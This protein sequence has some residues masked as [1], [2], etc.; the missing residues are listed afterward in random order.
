MKQAK[1][2]IWALVA[3]LFLMGSCRE[4]IIKTGTNTTPT[5]EPEI[6]VETSVQGRVFDAN[7]NPIP[8]AI[9]TVRDIQTKTDKNGFYFISGKK[10][11]QNGS[12]M[13][14]ERAGYFDGFKMI[15]ARLGKNSFV[16]FQMINLNGSYSGKFVNNQGAVVSN[17]SGVK[18]TFE[19]NE[20]TYDDGTAFDGEVL[21]FSHFIDPSTD[22]LRLEMPGDLRGFTK[23]GN[24][25]QL[26]TAGMVAVQLISA[27]GKKLQVKKGSTVTMEINIVED[28]QATAPSEI[29]LWSFD[30]SNGFWVEEGL[31]KR[32]GN[33]YIG[34]VAHFSYWN[35]DSSLPSVQLS[36]SATA[37]G[38]AFVHGHVTIRLNGLVTS[39]G[40][41]N[42]DG[43]F[44]GAVPKDETLE[45]EIKDI[46]GSVLYT[47][48]IGPFSTDATLD[49]V[50]LQSANEN[51]ILSGVVVDCDDNPVT[52]GYVK[53]SFA[54]YSYAYKTATDG[55]FNIAVINC[56]N[57]AINLYGV[58]IANGVE[59]DVINPPNGTTTDLGNVKACLNATSFLKVNVPSMNQEET[60]LY[61]T[62]QASN[63]LLDIYS[64]ESM[65]QDS[66][67]FNL[68]F[69]A[70]GMETGELE[71]ALL[72]YFSFSLNGGDLM[73][74]RCT[75]TTI[76]GT[77]DCGT[78]N[79]T[80][81]DGPGG[82]I[83]GSATIPAINQ[84]D[85][86][87]DPID[88]EVTFSIKRTD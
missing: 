84:L 36:G 82:F 23:E 31:A 79:I 11:N 21:V 16:D 67:Y 56:T 81:N 30:E 76:G 26:Q 14:V 87:Q 63:G 15:N 60:Y 42:D 86:S 88:V 38:L 46:C 9:V 80:S 71:L 12:Q 47:A 37:G 65:S 73:H 57:A 77:D 54:N 27:D 48:N 20:V 32:V 17:A 25:E 62:T 33:T 2:Y 45:M 50:D 74:L 3:I 83:K 44:G 35:Y 18:L 22:D 53:L 55:S 59:S 75:G 39:H 4:D 78:I 61:S 70:V 19:A 10:L 69:P 41:F 8:D 52:D 68:R 13:K 49:N 1:F 7:K 43:S 72:N 34:E 64:T 58:D 5:T 51:T 29:P 85:P 24:V 40:S 28:I 6:L 66:S